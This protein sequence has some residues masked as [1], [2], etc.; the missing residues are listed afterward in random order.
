MSAPFTYI[1]II[2]LRKGGSL[3]MATETKKQETKKQ[4][5]ERMDLFAMLV[6]QGYSMVDAYKK[7][8]N[9]Q[10]ETKPQYYAQASKFRKKPY[11]QAKIAE[12]REI[13]QEES[14]DEIRELHLF[15]SQ[16]YKNE[17]ISI[18]ERRKFSELLGKS[19][20]AFEPKNND[21]VDTT[22]VFEG[23]GDMLE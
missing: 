13:I 1:E 22:P 14:L 12:I 11:V 3:S 16:M 23:E 4:K 7:C 15:W 2:S 21:K 20:G 9:I 17:N 8:M 18:S 10:G 5:Q 6:V 19:L